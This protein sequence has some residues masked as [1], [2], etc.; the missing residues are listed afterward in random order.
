MSP[1]L[2]RPIVIAHRGASGYRPEHTLA[3][4]RLAIRMGADYIEPDLVS[5]RDGVLIARHENNI[6]ETTDVGRRAEF[7]SRRATRVIDGVTVTGWF[8]EDFTLD[9]IQSLRAVERLPA[10]RPGNDAACTS[11]IEDSRDLTLGRIPTLR[12]IIELVRREEAA[13]GRAIG[14]YP[15]TKHPTYF[16]R[17]G[18][19]LEEPLLEILHHYGYDRSD[20][21][22]FIQSFEVGNLRWLRERTLV[23][24]IQLVED[25]THRPFDLADGGDARTYGDLITRDGLDAVASYADGVG[26]WKELVVP[27]DGSAALTPSALVETAHRA[28]LLVHAWTLRRENYFLPHPDRR[29]LPPGPD[30]AEEAVH[31]YARAPGDLEGEARRLLALGIDGFFTDHPDIGVAAR[32][33]WLTAKEHRIEV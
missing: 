5:T 19:P 17:L 12:E 22:V 8:T 20:S 16:R 3:S 2:T 13:H 11:D 18:L 28:G 25:A 7:A 26:V 23:P 29:G 21:P 10:F 1:S 27:G 9:E 4:Y 6:A 30:A 15:E 14:I 31:D 24:L 32:D 33:H